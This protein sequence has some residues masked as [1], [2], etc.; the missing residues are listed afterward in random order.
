M[1]A[2]EARQII[3]ANLGR[4]ISGLGLEHWEI[5][6]NYTRLDTEYHMAECDVQYADYGR[7][8]IEFDCERMAAGMEPREVVRT[9]V[10]ELLHV[11]LSEYDHHRNVVMSMGPDSKKWLSAEQFSWSRACERTV[12]ILLYGVAR[13]LW[14]P[15]AQD[16][17]VNSTTAIT[18]AE[19]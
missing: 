8:V 10:H 7:A 12:A 17:G 15:E 2:D 6:V 18:A 1:T 9:L 4:V 14:D 16:Y 13:P 11:A 5:Q 3:S 19:E